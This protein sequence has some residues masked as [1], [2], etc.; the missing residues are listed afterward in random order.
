[1][2]SLSTWLLCTAWRCRE[3]AALIRSVIETA[4]LCCRPLSPHKAM[5][6][7]KVNN[8]PTT[9]PP[10]GVHDIFRQFGPVLTVAVMFSAADISGK[11]ALTSGADVTSLMSFRSVIGVGLVFVWLR[12]GKTAAALSPTAKWISL[13][14]GVVLAANLYAL[15]KA[16]EL[17]PVSIAVLTYFI[18]P[19]LTGIFGALTGIDRLTA[20]GAVTALVAFF[21]LAL[22]IGANPADLAMPGLLAAI[23]A[24][25]CRAAMLLITRATLKGADARL[26]T[27]YTLWS[28]TLL[29][30]MLSLLTWN[31]HWPHG[32]A[33]WT[34]FIAMAVTVTIGVFA[35]YV[36]TERIG[37]FRTALFM[38]L[39]PLMTSTFGALLLGERLTPVQMLGGVTMIAA[40]C[41]FQMRR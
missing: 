14:L 25:V 28:S 29:F 15:F 33:G 10:A 16:I 34:G 26:V 6:T 24:A 27:W 7:P 36:S 5:W 9:P 31:W 37:P 12:V 20:A 30:I 4:G 19:L 13:G 2:V 32:A 3:R 23:G 40:L 39:E 41:V 18:Y 1:M 8:C 38:N 17:V 11:V 21:G 35:L 22:I